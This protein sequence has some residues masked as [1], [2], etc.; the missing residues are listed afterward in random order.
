MFPVKVVRNRACGGSIPARL[1]EP[2]KL[3]IIW[4]PGVP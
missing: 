3:P 4:K 1:E 2:G